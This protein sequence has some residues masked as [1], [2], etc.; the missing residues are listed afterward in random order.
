MIKIHLFTLPIFVRQPL[1][2]GRLNSVTGKPVAIYIEWKEFYLSH[3]KLL[4]DDSLSVLEYTC[5]NFKC[6]RINTDG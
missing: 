1:N 2:I 3:P 5:N 6:I 4:S